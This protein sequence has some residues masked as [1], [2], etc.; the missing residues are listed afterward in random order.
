MPNINSKRTQSGLYMSKHE[1][2]LKCPICDSMMEVQDLKRITCPNRHTFDIAKQ[3]YLNVMTHPIKTGY[4]KA[5]FE[6]RRNVIVNSDFFG[7]FHTEMTGLIQKHATQSDLS[8]IDMGSGEGS[9]LYTIS[10]ILQKDHKHS[11]SAVG[12]DISKEGILEAAKNYE[13]HMWIVADL[14]KTPFHHH[15]F[16]VMLNILS[17]SNYE[18]FNRLLTDEGM[19]IKVVPRSKYLQELR[20]FFHGDS[21]QR[22]Y[23]N[24]KVVELFKNKFD[25]IDQSIIHYES[26]LSELDLQALIQMTPLSWGASADEINHFLNTGN[27]EVTVDL[28]ILIGKKKSE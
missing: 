20:E 28:D 18:E 1:S 2:I 7:P 10:N 26:T 4:D 24:E 21:E 11:I 5:L 27:R 19:V 13:N 17:P 9:H 3:G 23:S 22:N 14:A 12:I 25:L 16:D 15:T 6:A 8:I